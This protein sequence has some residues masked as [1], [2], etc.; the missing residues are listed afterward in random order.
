V[1]LYQDADDKILEQDIYVDLNEAERVG[2]SANLHI[3]AQVDRYAGGYAG[4]GDWSSARRYYVTQDN[5]LNRVQSEVVQE[6][7][8]VSMADGGTL[9]DFATWAIEAYPADRVAL[10]LSDHGMGWPGGWSDPQPGGPGDR[11]IPLASALGDQLYLHELDAALAEIR[12][13]TGL[14][15]F[16][17]IGM[18]AC[19]MGH[20]EVFTAL[21]EH[22]R[23][24]VASQETEPAVGWAYTSFLTALSQDTNQSGAE[25]GAFIV[26]SYIDEDQ[27]LLDDQ[28]RAELFRQSSPLAGLFGMLGVQSA[29]QV[30]QQMSQN[31]TL[32]AV[33]LAALPALLDALDGL[34]LAMQGANQS[35]VAEARAYAQS[36]TS[37]F[38]SNVPP[39]Y[40]DLGH[41]AS[42]LR[43]EAGAGDLTDAAGE[44]LARLEAAVIAERHGPKKP[45]ATGLSIYFPNSQLYRTP[46][47]GPASYTAIAN[48]FAATSLWDEFL[49]FHYAGV[50]FEATSETAAIPA[51]DG[52]TRAPGQGEL[53]A[54]PIELSSNVAAPGRPVLLSTDV[55]A[56][57]L[58]HVYLFVGLLD[59]AARSVLVADSDYLESPET[60]EVNRVFYPDWGAPEFRLEFEWEPVVFGISDGTNTE[61]ALFKP[62][63]YG[64]TYEEAV[65][66]VDG[67][68]R[69]AADGQ[70]RYARLS[71]SDG[72]LRHVYGFT[73]ADGVGAPREIYP[74]TGDS[75]TVLNEWLDLDAAGQVEARNRQEGGTLTFGNQPFTWVDLNAPVGQYVVGFVLEDLDGNR[76]HA[77]TTVAVE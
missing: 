59:E 69:Y 75:F 76:V 4:D 43:R 50:A 47:T 24:A 20:L 41:F 64:R 34:S 72:L 44:L 15:R 63:S 31:I 54:G 17:L 48:R 66:T 12:E 3:V 11:S 2:S 42:L 45:G 38:G 51:D 27:R 18:D 55:A 36:F 25:L 8:E 1:L 58:G 26:D 16:E 30:T 5:D 61:L 35:S 7:G 49:A 23:Y 70:T 6:L 71:F 28:A 40:I 39:S 52:I 57:N 14:E 73:G 19:L 21:A 9:V 68:Y 67:L 37:V 77:L 53:A 32:T 13:R 56:N 46:Q 10:I 33:D 65:Y 60:R 22:A 29:Q 62:G 74:E